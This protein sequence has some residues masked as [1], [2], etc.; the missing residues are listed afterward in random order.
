MADKWMQ[1]VSAG[2]KRR[3][4]KGVFRR[5]AEHAGESTHEFAEDNIAGNIGFFNTVPQG[6][7]TVTG[8]K[9]PS[10]VALASLLT[11]LSTY[12]LIHDTT[13]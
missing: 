12:G 2:I 1:G 11:A 8:A 4:T 5:A 10:D 13:T 7:Q 6:I 3:G 9:L